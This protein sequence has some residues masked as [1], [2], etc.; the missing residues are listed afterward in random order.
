MREHSHR[1]HQ[2]SML[3]VEEA[4]ERILS[5]VKVLEPEEQPLLS[6]LGLVLTENVVSRYDIP[7]LD[8]SA[9]ASQTASS[10]LKPASCSH[11]NGGTS[12]PSAA[13]YNT[14]L[15][16]SARSGSPSLTAYSKATAPSSP[17]FSA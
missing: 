4:L 7:P 12:S 8:N 10:T 16:R 6:A 17:T 1:H 5:F 11:R 3:D 9:M 15:M 2:E 13:M 14:S